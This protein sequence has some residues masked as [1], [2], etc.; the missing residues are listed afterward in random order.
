[1]KQGGLPSHIEHSFFDSQT[2]KVSRILS[3]VSRYEGQCEVTKRNLSRE[4]FKES[5]NFTFTT[6]SR[7][8]MLSFVSHN[9]VSQ[10]VLVDS[11]GQSSCILV[12]R[13]GRT[14]IREVVPCIPICSIMLYLRWLKSISLPTGMWGGWKIALWEFV[15]KIIM[16]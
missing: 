7:H 11:Y 16:G 4:R 5:P 12:T 9:I 1:M 6:W 10:K 14:S 3:T 15:V 13:N 8:G 2:L